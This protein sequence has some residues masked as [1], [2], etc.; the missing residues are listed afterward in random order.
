MR[1]LIFIAFLAISNTLFSQNITITVTG[2]W[3]KTIAASDISEAGNDYPTTYESNANQTLLTINPV[4]NNKQIIV[5][6]KRSDIAWHN[7]LNLKVKRTANGTNGN[8]AITGG[9]IYQTITNLNANFFTC[10]GY[11]TFIPLQYEITGISVVL[12]VQSYS[13]E[14]MYTVMH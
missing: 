6:V 13:T 2:N 10:V 4:N 8:T 5:Y 11:H 1:N 12:P 14:I 3:M 7:N 9:L